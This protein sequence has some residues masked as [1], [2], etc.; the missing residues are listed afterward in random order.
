MTDISSHHTFHLL[1]TYCPWPPTMFLWI[2]GML[3]VK[4]VHNTI[5][6]GAVQCLN[7]PKIHSKLLINNFKRSCRKIVFQ[8]KTS[9]FCAE[10]HH[11]INALIF[12]QCADM[13]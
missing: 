3:C 4:M 10:C 9:F 12:V 7:N 11:V 2:S 8:Y 5:Y 6:C 13:S 1:N